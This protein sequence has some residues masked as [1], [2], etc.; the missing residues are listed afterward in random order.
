MLSFGRRP[1]RGVVFEV[2]PRKESSR[3]V[4]KKPVVR[5]FKQARPQEPYSK[6]CEPLRQPRGKEDTQRKRRQATTQNCR[7][8]VY[9]LDRP[10]PSDCR[11][12]NFR[13][14]YHMNPNF[15]LSLL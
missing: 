9:P 6:T 3:Q 10:A 1:D 8:R 11:S 2:P 5:V 13:G 12:P 4:Q 14:R 15:G 7:P